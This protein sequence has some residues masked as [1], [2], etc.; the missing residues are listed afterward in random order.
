MTSPLPDKDSMMA[1]VD[2]CFRRYKRSATR[3][4]KAVDLMWSHVTQLMATWLVEANV[5]RLIRRETTR[6]GEVDHILLGLWK[7]RHTTSGETRTYRLDL[8]SGRWRRDRS[9]DRWPEL[10]L[11]PVTAEGVL[12]FTWESL[13]GD[14]FDEVFHQASKALKLPASGYN[15]LNRELVIRWDRRDLS[16]ACLILANDQSLEQEILSDVRYPMEVDH[17]ESCD[18]WWD[19]QGAFQL[20]GLDVEPRG[21]EH[22]HECAENESRKADYE[23]TVMK[24]LATVKA[25]FGDIRALNLGGGR[26]YAQLK[27]LGGYRVKALM[28]G[29]WRDALDRPAVS[30]ASRIEGT[31]AC[32]YLREVLRV[33]ANLGAVERIASE[34]PQWLPMLSRIHPRHWDRSDLFSRKL[35]VR[36]GGSEAPVDRR[37]FRCD[38]RLCSL[39]RTGSFRFLNETSQAGVAMVV[40][41]WMKLSERYGSAHGH[42]DEWLTFLQALAPSA[43]RRPAARMLAIRAGLILMQHYLARCDAAI[44]KLKQPAVMRLGRAWVA[45][46]L[47]VWQDQGYRELMRSKSR[48]EARLQQASDWC[49]SQDCRY[50]DR[51]MIWAAIERHSHTW[52]ERVQ[53]ETRRRREEQQRHGLGDAPIPKDLAWSSP[54]DAIQTDRF[55]ATPLTDSEALRVEGEVMHHCVSV[56]DENCHYGGYLVFSIVPTAADAAKTDRAT[57]GVYLGA[58]GFLLNQLYSYCNQPVSRDV[59]AF[60]DHVVVALNQ[61]LREKAA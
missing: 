29:L 26:S 59:R 51:N 27:T 49:L 60:A 53:A 8:A 61:S 38:R 58:G 14:A 37:S 21:A 6:R 4:E 30:L 31:R 52:H 5:T 11:L 24:R 9:L 47:T 17:C 35:W 57:L 22:C 1:S 43:D 46:R 33:Q 3:R 34:R 45:E 40:L 36:Q 41:G 23:R 54:I 7:I 44:D 39:E 13:V 55:V 16:K 10:K 48:D 42:I 15:H 20:E 32:L 25:Q 28:T 50:P 56:Y 12:A 2:R 19:E 18:R